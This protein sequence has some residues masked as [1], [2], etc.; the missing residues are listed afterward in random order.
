MSRGAELF[1]LAATTGEQAAA[2]GMS[3]A[4]IQR[5]RCGAFTPPGHVRRTIA[6]AYPSVA[7]AAWDELLGGAA[8][9]PALPPMPDEPPEPEP[10]NTREAAARHLVAVRAWLARAETAT[11]RAKGYEAMRKAIELQARLDGAFNSATDESRLAESPRYQ[12]VLAAV[13]DAIAPWPDALAAVAV[14]L[15]GLERSP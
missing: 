3:K 13:L 15:E 2:L 12:A 5:Y 10:A 8:P 14:A 6:E 9:T 7:V 11:E 1:A 4:Q